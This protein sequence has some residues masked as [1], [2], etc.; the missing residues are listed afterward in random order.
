MMAVIP[1]LVILAGLVVDSHALVGVMQEWEKV[2]VHHQHFGQD[3]SCNL[4]NI[5]NQPSRKPR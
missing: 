1:V 4:E 3:P 2:V 5:E